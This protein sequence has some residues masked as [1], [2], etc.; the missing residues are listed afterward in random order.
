MPKSPPPKSPPKS[1]KS[2][3][4]LNLSNNDLKKMMAM[5]VRE[6]S[7]TGFSNSAP[8]PALKSALKRPTGIKKRNKKRRV[9]FV[10]CPRHNTK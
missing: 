5:V 1:P 2:P 4:S 6:L 9:M 10:N 3:K 8:K 7:K